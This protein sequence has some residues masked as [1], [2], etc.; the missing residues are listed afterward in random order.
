MVAGPEGGPCIGNGPY[1]N[2]PGLLAWI[3]KNRISI[4]LA[5]S[6][7]SG[8]VEYIGEI[9]NDVGAIIKLWDRSPA[10]VIEAACLA[11]LRRKIFDVHD[12]QPPS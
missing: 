9:A 5:V 3:F 7:R 1:W 10:G 2:I 4:A 8:V 6:G 11:H 12:S